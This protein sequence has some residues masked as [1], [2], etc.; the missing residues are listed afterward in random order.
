MALEFPV[1]LKMSSAAANDE[2]IEL[3]NQGYAILHWMR[4]D[5]DSK[6]LAGAFDDSKDNELYAE[7][8][9]LWHANVVERLNAIFPTELEA[10]RFQHPN[11]A[12]RGV[13]GDYKFGSLCLQVEDHLRGLDE[14]RTSSIPQYTDLPVQTRLFA[15]DIDSFRKVRDVNPAAV[16]DLLKDGYFDKPEDFVQMAL[17]QILNVSL[18]K[19]D[20]GGEYNDLYIANL[21][22]YGARVESAFLLKGN[23]L[24]K[25]VLEIRD[26]GKNGDQLVRLFESPARVFVIQF[27]GNISEV[28][29][30]D[31]E[32]KIGALRAIKRQAWYCLVDGQDTTRILRAY[33]KV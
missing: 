2:L 8:A 3:I 14:I 32:G 28:I 18:H 26:C 25:K 22:L 15:E 4:Q 27:V 23:G 16:A 31:V 24:R 7:H 20:W 30:K 33:G 9:N 19:Q 21:I 6:R 11:T 13:S 29:A 10:N 12:M 17:E 5:H 1:R